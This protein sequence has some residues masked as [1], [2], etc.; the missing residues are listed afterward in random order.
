MSAVQT[1]NV[2]TIAYVVHEA[3]GGFQL[4]DVILHAMQSDEVLVDMQ[5]SGICQRLIA[6]C[7]HGYKTDFILA[8][9]TDLVFQQGDIRVC[10]YP[11]IFGHEGAGTILALGDSVNPKRGLKVGDKVLLSINYCER[12]RFCLS[13]HPADCIE[14]RLVNISADDQGQHMLISL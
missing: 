8:G 13:N 9:H 1:R 11:A 12:C 5:Y 14:G 7:E 2:E 10:S 4:E 3:K 6:C